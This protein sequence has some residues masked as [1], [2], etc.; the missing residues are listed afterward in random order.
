MH[1]GSRI[2]L[3]ERALRRNLRFLRPLC[4]E[5]EFS[6]VVKGNAYGHGIETFVPLAEACGVRHFSVFSAQEARRVLE[7]S[8][9]GSRIMVMGYIDEQ[10]MD[11]VVAN[12][13]SF[14]AFD[15]ARLES[16]AA[17]AGRVGRPARVHLQVETGMHRLGLDRATLR[18]A[19]GR[20]LESR[21]R[22][23]LAG[24]STHLAGPESI[25]NHVRVARQLES[26]DGA[27]TLLREMG[28]DV[29][30]RHVAN[31][32]A[33]FMYPDSVMDMVRCGIAQY[34]FW[35]GTE[36]RM[37]RML[38]DCGDGRR[39]WRDPLRRVLTWKSCI[40][41]LKEVPPGEFIGYG[42]GCQTTRRELIASVP[43]GYFD[44]FPRVLSNRGYVL[45][46]GH[47]ARV[48]GTVN[49]S[50]ML[51]SVTHVPG[52]RKGDEVVIIGS[53]GRRRMTV[54]SFSDMTDVMNYEALVRLPSEIPRRVV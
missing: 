5:A 29:P 4:G 17:A 23:E 13:I 49:M 21:G 36:V 28:L 46:R 40:M 22:M 50:M 39:S 8:R 12:G 2:E 34:G 16:A 6:S 19:A 32:A 47:R 35:P 7:A 45:V 26:F 41:S 25:S 24:V 20:I 42:T 10:D 54:A 44:G 11:W 43:I 53:Q 1:P 48:V 27:C 52:A 31:S 15:I 18:A 3:S 30:V 51:V 38:S 33:L 14:M 37:H 9:R